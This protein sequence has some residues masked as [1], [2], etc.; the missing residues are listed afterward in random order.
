MLAIQVQPDESLHLEFQAKA[1]DENMELK[2]VDFEFH[3]D[4]S[5]GGQAIPDAYERLLLDALNGDASLFTRSD[6]IG[7]AWEI[8][9]PIIQGLALPDAPQPSSY[10]IG[11]R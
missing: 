3:C 4:D 7:E 9:A 8:M 11:S 5:F 6:E 1:P 10:P 2:P